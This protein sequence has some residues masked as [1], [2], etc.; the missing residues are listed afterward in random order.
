METVQDHATSSADHMSE[1]FASTG[2]GNSQQSQRL[3]PSGQGNKH[4]VI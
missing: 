3:M 4:N 2:L 1:S